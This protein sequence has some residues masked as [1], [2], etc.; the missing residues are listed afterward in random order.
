MTNVFIERLLELK[1][2]GD[3]SVRFLQP[4]RASIDWQCTFEIDWPDRRCCRQIFGVDA[5]QALLLSMR[6]A[7]AELLESP[8]NASGELTWLGGRDF[9]LPLIGSSTVG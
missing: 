6:V 8:E 5:I 1:N 7:H 3:V 2:G 9:D 4:E